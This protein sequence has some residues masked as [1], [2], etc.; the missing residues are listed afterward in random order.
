M[1]SH[2]FWVDALTSTTSIPPLSSAPCHMPGHIT[3]SVNQIRSETGRESRLF[4]KAFIYL[5]C[6][7]RIE[8][9]NT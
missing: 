7:I 2:I 8:Y 5:T 1:C 3:R 9:H 4:R 6:L